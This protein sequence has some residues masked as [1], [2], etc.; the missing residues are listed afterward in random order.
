M[1]PL[2][3]QQVYS[4]DGARWLGTVQRSGSARWTALHAVRLYGGA[5]LTVLEWSRQLGGW[6]AWDATPDGRQG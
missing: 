4:A 5:T 1:T 3:G 2:A 6:L